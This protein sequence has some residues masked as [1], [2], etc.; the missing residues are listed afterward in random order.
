MKKLLVLLSLI[1]FTIIICGGCQQQEERTYTDAEFQKLF[2]NAIKLWNGGDIEIANS[3]Y[4]E[5]CIYHNADMV[6]LKGV[7]EIKGFIKWVYTAYPDFKVTFDEPMKLKDR[8]VF[9][10][11][12]TATNE[13]PLGENMPPTGKKMSF[14]GVS[15]VKVE[16]GRIIE[17]WNNY[18]QLPIY[19]QLGYKLVPVEEEKAK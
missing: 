7:E 4:A 14:N 6:E 8:I 9:K 15:I 13:G 18:N 3:Q 16:N 2:D 1:L 12:A 5:G 10:Y 17:E 19:K 11:N